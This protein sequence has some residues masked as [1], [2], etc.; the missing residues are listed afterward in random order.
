V[1]GRY[2]LFTDACVNGHLV[3]ALIGRGWDVE[4]AIGVFPA[5]T[6]DPV[7]FAHAAQH[8][9][10]FVSNDGPIERLALTWL[11]EG[12]HFRMIFWPQR[13]YELWTVGELAQAFDELAQEDEPFA[14]P[15]RRLRPTRSP[16]LEV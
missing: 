16:G 2:P 14:Y 3:G 9:R 5:G 13:D 12:R 11:G 7:V 8:G 1:A 10:V 4:R 6:S 15:I